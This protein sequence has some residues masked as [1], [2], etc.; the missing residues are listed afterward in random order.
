M[1]EQALIK[2]VQSGDDNAMNSLI[3]GYYQS[4]FAFFYKNT[5]NYHQS[6][7]LTQ[8]V[9]I[10]MAAGIS[11][12]RPKMP[13][14]NWLFTIASNHLKNYYRTLS[15]RPGCVELFDEYVAADNDIADFGVKNDIKAALEHLPPEQKEAVILRYYNDFSIKDISKITGAKET[16][17]K[18]RIRYGL[19]KLKIELEGYNE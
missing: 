4:V 6:E 3:S 7:D 10:K 19:E 17:V 18:A 2:K 16:T 12:Y 15:R 1:E 8:E 9:F 14:K 13:F 5:G 11:S